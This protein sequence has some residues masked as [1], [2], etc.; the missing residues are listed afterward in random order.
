MHVVPPV[1]LEHCKLQ[2][3]IDLT[4]K[5]TS[6]FQHFNGTFGVLAESGTTFWAQDLPDPSWSPPLQRILPEISQMPPRDVQET[7][8]DRPETS[9]R[10]PRDLV[11]LLT[12]LLAYLPTCLLACLLTGLLACLL[13]CLLTYVLT[14]L[15]AYLLAFSS[16]VGER[17]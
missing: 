13:A 10:P 1:V 16:L 12:C 8:R 11:Y 14:C 17:P 3:K 4:L 7:S 5:N 9:Q 6:F 2:Y 15:L